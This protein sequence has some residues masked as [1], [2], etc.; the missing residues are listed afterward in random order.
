MKKLEEFKSVNFSKAGSKS[1]VYYVGKVILRK[2]WLDNMGITKE[3]PNIKL[4][5]DESSKKI[6]IEKINS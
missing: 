6:I 2:E 4:N 5:Y 3:E 1:A